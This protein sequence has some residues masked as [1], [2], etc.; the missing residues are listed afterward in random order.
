M[1]KLFKERLLRKAIKIL[2]L[3]TEH[4]TYFYQKTYVL[5]LNCERCRYNRV[6][7]GNAANMQSGMW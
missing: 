3:V 4:S 2:G 6:K 7:L 1:Q 5:K